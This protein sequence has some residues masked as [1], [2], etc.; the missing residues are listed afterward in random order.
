MHTHTYLYLYIHWLASHPVGIYHM[1][2]RGDT[3][4]QMLIMAFLLVLFLWWKLETPK[5]P[6]LG[7]VPMQWS[8]MAPFTVMIYI[9]MLMPWKLENDKQK[10]SLL[11]ISVCRF[12]IDSSAYQNS[13]S[14]ISAD[15]IF[16]VL[17]CITST[18]WNEFI[19]LW[20]EENQSYEIFFD[21][22]LL[23]DIVLN[24]MGNKIVLVYDFFTLWG[25]GGDRKWTQMALSKVRACVL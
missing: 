18:F 23:K 13:D 12:A 24:I 20:I 17:F 21:Y 8:T 16:C 15:F 2:R 5:C 6:L 3:C 25:E 1:K 4:L 19:W 10:S 7:G 22:L 14:R 9:C 11:C